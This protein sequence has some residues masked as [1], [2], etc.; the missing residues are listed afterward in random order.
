MSAPS[1]VALPRSV[2]PG[3]VVNVSVSLVAPLKPGT[4]RGNWML[5]DANGSRF[6]LGSNA[7]KPFWVKIIVEEVRAG[8]VYDFA[9]NYCSAQWKSSAGPLPC[10]GRGTEPQGF[11]VRL[12]NP[13]LENRHEDE[14]TLWTSPERKTEGWISG[15]YPPIKVQMGDRFLADIGCLADSPMCNVGF[16]LL[17]R[18]DGGPTIG[19]GTW[20][21]YY[22]GN[23]THLILDLSPLAGRSVEFT[24]VVFTNGEYN[25]DNAFWLLPHIRR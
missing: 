10:P 20:Y 24:L 14:L 9:M 3:D 23:I 19:L 5:R 21:E 13:S 6:G 2:T 8:V 16:Q 12:S 4:Y 17:Y 1:A 18:A 15:T 11:V 25:Q 7:D 22:D